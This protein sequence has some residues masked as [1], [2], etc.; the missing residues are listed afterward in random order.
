[1]YVHKVNE[2]PYR[3]CTP[4]KTTT[5]KWQAPDPGQANTFVAGLNSYWGTNNLLIYDSGVT[6]QLKNKL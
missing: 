4:L 3:H 5:S 2:K 6:V 1:M